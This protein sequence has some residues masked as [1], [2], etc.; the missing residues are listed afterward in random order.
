MERRRLASDRQS[1]QDLGAILSVGRAVAKSG[2]KVAKAFH[3]R[4]KA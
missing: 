2:N 3:T 4:G 1:K